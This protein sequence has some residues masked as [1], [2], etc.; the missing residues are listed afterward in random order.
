MIFDAAYDERIERILYFQ[1][2]DETRRSGSKSPNGVGIPGALD[3]LFLAP[4]TEATLKQTKKSLAIAEFVVDDDG[5]GDAG[6]RGR[7]MFGGRVG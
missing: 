2:G 5:R 1:T 4:R 7:N 3:A 6:G